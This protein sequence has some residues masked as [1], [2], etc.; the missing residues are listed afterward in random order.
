MLRTLGV[1]WLLIG[2]SLTAV[3]VTGGHR[4]FLG[5]PR[6]WYL[7]L[8]PGILGLILV[9]GAVAILLKRQSGR[10]FL[11]IGAVYYAA[12]FRYDL[13]GEWRTL[14]SL[15]NWSLFFFLWALQQWQRCV[16]HYAV[17]TSLILVVFG[18]GVCISRFRNR[19]PHGDVP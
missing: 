10:L 2:M 13:P 18:T 16:V 1:V 17:I 11:T 12:K 5:P 15:G 6:R 19:A 8:E 9:G 7:D 3:A 14:R 4:W